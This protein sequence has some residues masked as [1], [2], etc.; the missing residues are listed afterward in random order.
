MGYWFCK[1]ERCRLQIFSRWSDYICTHDN[2]QTVYV[3]YREGLFHKIGS[4]PD[5]G[6]RKVGWQHGT[7]GREGLRVGGT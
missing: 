3:I 7:V 4:F 5:S 1:T 6:I 2:A